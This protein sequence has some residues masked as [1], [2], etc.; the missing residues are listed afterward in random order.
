M[1]W[2][3]GTSLKVGSQSVDASGAARVARLVR[4]VR[5]VRLVRLVKLYKY[6]SKLRDSN[7]NVVKEEEQDEMNSQVGA[8]MS[9]LTN[10]R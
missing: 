1:P 9:D 8:L 6:L 4:V 3:I 2:V 7:N 10:R 5:M